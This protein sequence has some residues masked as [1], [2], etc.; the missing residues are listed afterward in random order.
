MK[1]QDLEHIIRASGAVSG[2]DELI[3]IGSQAILGSCPDAPHELLVSR[4]ADVYPRRDPEKADLIDGSIG[5]ASMFE[6]E[7]GYYAHGV[8]PETAILPFEW[9]NRLVRVCNENTGGVTGWCLSPVDIAASKL[10]AGRDRDLDFVQ[11]LIR[12]GIVSFN[13]VESALNA[14]PEAHR[15]A[16]VQRLQRISG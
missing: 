15:T 5:E 3:I 12:H 11:G 9:Q 13:E 6:E 14:L 4:E 7:F 8:G 16:A 1:R 10:A 2:T